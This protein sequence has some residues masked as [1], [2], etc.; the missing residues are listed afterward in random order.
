MAGKTRLVGKNLN[1]AEKM[2]A[3]VCSF[4]DHHNVKYTL[5]GG[6]LLGIIRENR[7]LPWDND[8]DLTIR[9]EDAS[10]LLKNLWK[11]KLSGLRIR[12]KKFKKNVGPFAIDELRIVKVRN[13][14]YLFFRGDV[15]IDIFVKRRIEDKYFWT[16]G[17]KK[18]V[19]KSSPA[20]FYENL[21]RYTFKNQEYSVPVDYDGYLTYRYGDW[22]TPVKTWNFKKDDQAIINEGDLK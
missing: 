11:L 6:T 3:K 16:V 21:T 1:I 9:E 2:L 22:H 8:M 15:M 19:L 5:E 12:V 18:P 20:E 17:I 10:V 13:F 4:L 7:L 14:K